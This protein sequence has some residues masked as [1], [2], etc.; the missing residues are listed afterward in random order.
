MPLIASAEVT[1]PNS[2]TR[3]PAGISNWALGL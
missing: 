2:G 1:D 3:L